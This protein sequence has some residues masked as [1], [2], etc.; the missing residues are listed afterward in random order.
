MGPVLVT[1]AAGF[2]GQHLVNRLVKGGFRVRALV[3]NGAVRHDWGQNVE[4]VR[5]DVRDSQAARLAVS[6]VDTIF[7]L[8]G[9]AHDLEEVKDTGEH[10][11]VTVKGTQN[12]IT[13]GG[14]SGIKRFIFM[15][16]LSIYPS[17]SQTI[18]DEAL[19]CYPTSAYGRA[20]FEAELCVLEMG[21]RLGIHVCCLRPATV[22]GPGCKGNLPRMI[23]MVDRGLFPPLPE[24]GNRRSIVHVV[25]VVEAAMLAA[26]N[27]AADGKCYVVT[28]SKA[29]STRELYEMISWALGK[30]VPSWHVPLW[31]LRAVAS[32]GDAIG[33]LRGRRFL[34]DSDALEKLIGTAWYTSEKISDEL[35]YH[36]TM[37][38]ENA[39]PD[40]IAWYRK[41]ANKNLAFVRKAE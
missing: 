10:E 30:R 11:E 13:A 23:K 26:T 29:Y 40:L 39:L 34:F 14:E 21:R 5:G 16:S 22:Y 1:G 31:A 4:V 2:I 8:A 27:P 37:T 28:D 20:K 24:V 19:T 25:N 9:K 17:T 41:S 32:V 36:P 3:R 12:L 33:R 35:G 18:Q 7:H 6:D 38:F 15:S